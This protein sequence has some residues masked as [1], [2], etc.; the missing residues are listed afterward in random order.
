VAVWQVA[1]VAHGCDDDR[2]TSEGNGELMHDDAINLISAPEGPSHPVSDAM[3][4]GIG[5]ASL[6]SPAAPLNGAEKPKSS[7]YARLKARHHALIA[8]HETLR[9]DFNALSE[10][11]RQVEA[12][13]YENTELLE[14]LGT[15]RPTQQPQYRPEPT[16][17]LQSL[18]SRGAR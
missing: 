4:G 10:M 3:S 13:L 12:A 16:V 17:G 6:P 8:E 7:G 9:G 18:F 14:R 5:V 1:H 2:A 11:Y 15:Q